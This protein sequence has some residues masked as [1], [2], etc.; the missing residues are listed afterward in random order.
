MRRVLQ[1]LVFATFFSPLPFTLLTVACMCPTV[2]SKRIIDEDAL[3]GTVF[4][5]VKRMKHSETSRKGSITEAQL[6]QNMIEE[7]T[8]VT[9]TAFDAELR[10]IQAQGDFWVDAVDD[11]CTLFP[12]AKSGE[13]S[14]VQ[15]FFIEVM[16]KFAVICAREEKA[17]YRKGADDK[18]NVKHTIGDVLCIPDATVHETPTVGSRK[19]DVNVYYEDKLI[20]GVLRIIFSWELKSRAVEN[21]HKFSNEEIGQVIDTG[22]ELLRQ[23]PFRQFTLAVLTDG[24]RFVFFKISRVRH[25]VE[26][27]KVIQS[28]TF[29]NMQGWAVSTMIMLCRNSCTLIELHAVCR[30]HSPC[31]FNLPRIS[32]SSASLCRSTTSTG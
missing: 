24:V 2:G 1:V 13:K 14:T 5:M 27:F 30:S 25:Q 17:V 12:P 3:E 23:Q 32:V 8:L 18:Y 4:E 10:A 15:P 22:M 26:E 21:N 28:N 31:F 7:G 16:D 11:P 9:D 19:P 29:L 20:K 6:V